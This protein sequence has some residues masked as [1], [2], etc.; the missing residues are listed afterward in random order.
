MT[1]EPTPSLAA[2][3]T[4]SDLYIGLMSGT[5]LDGVD[6]VLARLPAN[7]EQASPEL[8]AHIH[9]P[10]SAELRAALL[11]LQAPAPDEIQQEA[12]AGNRLANL[13][14]TA[15]AQVLAQAQLSANMV[16]AVGSHGQTIRHRPELGYT[17]Q[18]QN[19]ALLAEL[20]GIDVIADFRSR[21]IAAGG[22]GAP[23]VPAFHQALFA[24]SKETRV[25]VNIG[26]ISNIS[27]LGPEQVIGFDTGPGNVFLDTWIGQQHGLPYDAD[28]SWAD[29]GAV[30]PDLLQALL[31]E[32]FLALPPPKSTGRDLFHGPWL[33]Q[34]LVPFASVPAA[35][36][37]ATLA[38]LTAT[39]IADAIHRHAPE[40]SAVYAC[41]GGVFNRCLMRLLEQALQRDGKALSLH[42]T[43]DMGIA[44]MQVEALAFAWLA[45]QFCERRP[46]NLPA[47]TGARGPR[48]LGALYP[49]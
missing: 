10:F 11:L 47:V 34:R 41:G 29:S 20:C 17:R 25:V 40:A 43:T 27:I 26:G 16:R 12:L 46:G 7:P 28:G 18:I 19:P 37:Q 32:P 39:T 44:P 1:P 23:L 4:D 31:S 24:S 15:A 2:A 38:A 45:Q 6:A 36:V 35:D 30:N 3:T 33:Q 21:D 48:I 14:A 5:S 22:Q 9:L 8:L 49:R 13:Y 42:T